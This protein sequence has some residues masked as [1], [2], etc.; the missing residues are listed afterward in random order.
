[1][2]SSNLFPHDGYDRIANAVR[3]E[4]LLLFQGILI[5]PQRRKKAVAYDHREKAASASTMSVT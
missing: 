5:G 2:W 1:M 3:D 4:D